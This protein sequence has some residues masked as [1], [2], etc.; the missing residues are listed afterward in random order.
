MSSK[1]SKK[2]RTRLRAIAK[3]YV[4]KGNEKERDLSNHLYYLLLFIDIYL[5]LYLYIQRECNFKC[6]IDEKILMKTSPSWCFWEK[7]G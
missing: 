7:K 5:Y 6:N 2:K 4:D 3:V 1:T